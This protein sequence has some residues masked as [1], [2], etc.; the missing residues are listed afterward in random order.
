MIICVCFIHAGISNAVPLVKILVS[1]CDYDNKKV[2]TSGFLGFTNPMGEPNHAN[3]IEG[4]NLSL[5]LEQFY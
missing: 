4:D 1:P 3:T 5:A 2:F